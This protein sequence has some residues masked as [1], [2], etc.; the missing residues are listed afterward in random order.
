M[1]TKEETFERLT[2]LGIADAAFPAQEDKLALFE[3]IL[4]GFL[5]GEGALFVHRNL[6]TVTCMKLIVDRV[7]VL[8]LYY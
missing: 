7:V 5:V 2:E 8:S 6:D 1:I 3:A 4:R